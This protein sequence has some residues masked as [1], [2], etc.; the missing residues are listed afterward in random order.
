VGEAPPPKGLAPEAEEVLF[1]ERSRGG[2]PV[3]VKALRPQQAR[4]RHVRKYAEGELPK[5]FSF[6]F[7][8]PD[9][10]LNLRAQNLMLFAQI[11]EGVD[12]ATWEHHRRIHDY[13]GWFRRVIKDDD[14]TAEAKAAE[15]DS[16]LDPSESRR[17]IIEAIHS[18]LYGTR[19]GASLKFFVTGK[20]V[21]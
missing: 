21:S 6:Y 4:N 7:R 8:G 11:A 16:T 15:S 14:L 2:A 13:S 12:D 18:A 9:N 17:R 3:P 20:T 10:K 19:K 5:D 1:W